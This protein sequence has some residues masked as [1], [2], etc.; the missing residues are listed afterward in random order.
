[1]C[2]SIK[3]SDFFPLFMSLDEKSGNWVVILDHSVADFL[4]AIQV[5]T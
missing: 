1:M 5:T 2:N 3:L 4:F